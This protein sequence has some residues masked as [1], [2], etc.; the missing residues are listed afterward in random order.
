M[1]RPYRFIVNE[2]E[3]L[4]DCTEIVISED[5]DTRIDEIKNVFYLSVDDF[6]TI[7]K[8]IDRTATNAQSAARSINVGVTHNL[9]ANR[10]GF[11][12][13]PVDVGRSPLRRRITNLAQGGEDPLSQ[14]EQEAILSVLSNNTRSIAEAKPEKLASL[15]RDMDLVTLDALIKRYE[16]MIKRNLHEN[17]CKPS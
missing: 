4:S 14:D 1:T 13:T 8:S 5:D 16:K 11:P 10:L 3:R 2:V 12:E 9:L 7:R 15:Q 6:D 17:L